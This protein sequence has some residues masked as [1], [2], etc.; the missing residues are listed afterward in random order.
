MKQFEHF[1]SLEY[2]CSVASEL[3]RTGLRSTSSPFDWCISNFAG[4]MDAIENHFADF[5]AY[6]RLLQSDASCEYY[7]I[8]TKNIKYGFFTH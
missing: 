3:E 4:V 5:L 2:F 8:L 1:I 7:I 6:D